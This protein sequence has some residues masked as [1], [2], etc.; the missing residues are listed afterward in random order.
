MIPSLQSKN[1]AQMTNAATL[2]LTAAMVVSFW[3][4]HPWLAVIA[5]VGLGF[6][7]VYLL[8]VGWFLDACNKENDSRADAMMMLAT[9]CQCAHVLSALAV[10]VLFASL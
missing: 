8:A 5:S 6:V 9:C 3:N 7:L 4:H 10:L 2:I 1:D